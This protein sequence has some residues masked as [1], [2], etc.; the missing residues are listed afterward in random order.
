LHT[1]LVDLLRGRLL[2]TPRRTAF[3]WAHV[4]DTA[5]GHLLAMERGQPGGT[6]ILAGPRHT[7]EE[8]FDLVA[9]LGNVRRPLLHPGP[10]T[11]RAAAALMGLVPRAIELPPAISPEGLRVIAGTTYLGSNAKAVRELGFTVRSLAEG[12]DQTL[13]HELRTLQRARPPERA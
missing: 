12:M 8:A 1:A 7:F 5:R 10:R 4:E 6:Y 3:C 11:L 13:E 2:A 9:R